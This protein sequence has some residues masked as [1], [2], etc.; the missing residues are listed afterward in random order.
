MN[1]GVKQLILDAAMRYVD[2]YISNWG[3]NYFLNSE[4][5]PADYDFYIRED[6]MICYSM[7]TGE[8]GRAN[9]L[10]R[11]ELPLDI[12]I[13]ESDYEDDGRRE[14]ETENVTKE[15]PAEKVTPQ[16]TATPEEHTYCKDL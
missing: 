3:I 16:V 4:T 13:D 7:D 6:G 8:F 15:E 9:Y 5:N 10:G 1:E 11:E 2:T 14:E 12:W